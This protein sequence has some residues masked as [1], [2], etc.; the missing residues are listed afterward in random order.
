M[1][2]KQTGPAKPLAQHAPVGVGVGQAVVEQAEFTPRQTPPPAAQ[3]ASL[4]MVQTTVPSAASARQH[5]PVAALQGFGVHEE[6]APRH[7]PPAIAWQAASVRIWQ[8][9]IGEPAAVRQHAPVGAVVG[10]GLG[11]Q[12]VPAPRQVP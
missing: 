1:V 6:L 11:E 7:T 8:G 5:A 12:L 9:V 3:S 4:V 10:Q 2:T